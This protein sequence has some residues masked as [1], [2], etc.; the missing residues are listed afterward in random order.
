MGT[1]SITTIIDNAFDTKDKLCTMYR[2]YDGYPSGHGQELFDFLSPFT[3]VNGM[4]GSDTRKIANGAGCL[5][6]QMIKHFK[7][8]AGGIYMVKTHTKLEDEDYG[9]EITITNVR[10]IS[11]VVRSDSGVI[12]KGSLAEFGIF[13]SKGE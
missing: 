6:A 3:S 1:R 12:F 11:V 5:A 9:Y 8:G 7:E 10:T 2:Q 4:S 13:C